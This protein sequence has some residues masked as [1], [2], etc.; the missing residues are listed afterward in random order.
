MMQSEPLH[1]LHYFPNLF[2]LNKGFKWKKQTNKQIKNQI[3]QKQKTKQQQ[4]KTHPK[5]FYWFHDW[6]AAMNGWKLH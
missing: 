1:N 4:K 5:N 3:K 2:Y 6:C